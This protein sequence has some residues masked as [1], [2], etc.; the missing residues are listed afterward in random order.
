MIFSDRIARLLPFFTLIFL[1]LPYTAQAQTDKPD[2]LEGWGD[3][4]SGQLPST[5]TDTDIWQDVSA[6]AAHTCALKRSGQLRCWGYDRDFSGST[7]RQVSGPNG[8]TATYKV[9]KSVI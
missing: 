8:S 7:S 6:G 1:T 5:D 9:T 4:R 3:N 2:I